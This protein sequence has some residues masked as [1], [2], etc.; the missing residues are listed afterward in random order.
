MNLF[1]CTFSI[2]CE[3]V[4]HIRFKTEGR[5]GG[6]MPTVCIRCMQLL[7]LEVKSFLDRELLRLLLLVLFC[8]KD[9]IVCRISEY[10]QI[11]ISVIKRAHK[12][13][14]VFLNSRGTCCRLGFV[15]INTLEFGELLRL[16]KFKK[17]FSLFCY[18]SSC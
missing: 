18:S 12:I 1:I 3:V 8:V 7:T 16:L 6:R 2:A 13:I 9:L 5:R 14:K 11:I 17:V 15:F 10:S 4:G